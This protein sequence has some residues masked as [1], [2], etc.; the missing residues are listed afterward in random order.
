MYKVY[1]IL[2]HFHISAHPRL[3]LHKRYLVLV[4]Y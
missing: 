3:L 1:R 2:E 4:I